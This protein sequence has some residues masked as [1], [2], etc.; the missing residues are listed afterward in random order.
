MGKN[1]PQGINQKD[2]DERYRSL[3][4]PWDLGSPTP[5]FSR[6]LQ[7][8][9]FSPNSRVIIPGAGRGYDAVHFAQHSLDVTTLDFSHEANLELANLAKKKSVEIRIVEEDFFSFSARPDEQERYD[10][11]L[12]YTFYCAIDPSLRQEYAKAAAQLLKPGAHFVG[13]FFPLEE[14]SGGPPFAVRQEEVAEEFGKYFEL[15]FIPPVASIRPRSGREVLAI[16]QK[17]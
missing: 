16:L 15:S 6:L 14:R 12:E 9:F 1:D 11:L 10:Y 8:G 4:T 5:E 2:W 7:E 17:K 3:N 13:L